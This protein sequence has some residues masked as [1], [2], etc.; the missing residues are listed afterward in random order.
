MDNDVV[1]SE[2]VEDNG[3]CHLDYNQN[4]Q[5]RNGHERKAND[6]RYTCDQC[7]KSFAIPSDLQKHKKFI[8][9]AI[10]S[11]VNLFT[12]KECGKGFKGRNGLQQHLI[13]H[14]GARPH[15]CDE[16]EMSFGQT[17]TLA[18]HKKFVHKKIRPFECEICGSRTVTAQNFRKH[19]LIHSGIKI[20]NEICSKFVQR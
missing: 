12:C 17:S 19:A 18:N 13:T 7:D 3:K 5:I 8:H 16:C 10:R 6:K 1:V 20:H 4:E 9:C 15:A 11:H 14:T 2:I